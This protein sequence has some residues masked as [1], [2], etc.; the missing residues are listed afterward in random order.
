MY[1]SKT[2]ALDVSELIGLLRPIALN[3]LLTGQQL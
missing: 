1:K 2:G 3:T